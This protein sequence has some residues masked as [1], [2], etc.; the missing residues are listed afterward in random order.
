M[1]NLHFFNDYTNKSRQINTEKLSR[2]WSILQNQ[3]KEIMSEIIIMPIVILI[4]LN[5]AINQTKARTKS[6]RLKVPKIYRHTKK[7]ANY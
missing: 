5:Q 4:S 6:L 3:L 7:E 1:P 2:F